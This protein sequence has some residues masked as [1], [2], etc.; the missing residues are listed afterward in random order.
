MWY[1]CD[2]ILISHSILRVKKYFADN[3]ERIIP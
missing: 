2:I 1:H 3:V